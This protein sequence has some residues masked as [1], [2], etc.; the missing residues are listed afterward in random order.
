MGRVH[1]SDDQS[2]WVVHVHVKDD[3]EGEE[4][5]ICRHW[6]TA[7]STFPIGQTNETTWQQRSCAGIL[8]TD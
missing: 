8:V 3:G 6:N 4:G 7:F 1:S 2:R 5:T